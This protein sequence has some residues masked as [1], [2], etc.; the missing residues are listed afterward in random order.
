[1]KDY[2]FE[3]YCK[4]CGRPLR[5]DDP[6]EQGLTADDDMCCPWCELSGRI[7]NESLE[8]IKQIIGGKDI[9]SG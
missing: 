6:H 9:S 3:Y 4:W 2:P 7:S 8:A 5:R 1:M